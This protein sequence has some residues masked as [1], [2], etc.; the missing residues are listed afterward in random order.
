MVQIVFQLVREG[1]LKQYVER[2]DRLG[3]EEVAQIAKQILE[4]LSYL[5]DK[6]IIHRDL[7]CANIL[8][9][10]N[11]VVKI[12]DFGTARQIKLK[13]NQDIAKLC[14]SLKGTPYYMAP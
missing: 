7:K 12:T 9:D 14:A 6:N 5:H 3:E 13:T 4:A 1:T 8:M 10:A 11:G 2:N